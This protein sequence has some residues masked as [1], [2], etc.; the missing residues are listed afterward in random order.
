MVLTTLAF[1]PPPHAATLHDGGHVA[2]PRDERTP[3]QV[4]QD[5]KLA[6]AAD[7]RVAM[8]EIA[9]RAAFVAKNTA[10]LRELRLEKEA[11]DARAVAEAPP[12]EPAKKKRAAKP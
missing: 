8:Q 6:A 5:R 10:R 1:R 11:S 7:G 3:K 4:S 9:E 2:K 12:A